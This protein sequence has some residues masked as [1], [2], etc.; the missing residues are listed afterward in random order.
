VEALFADD[1]E[2]AVRSWVIGLAG[3]NWRNLVKAVLAV[4]GDVLLLR[5]DYEKQGTGWRGGL[6]VLFPSLVFAV[7]VV[8]TCK[9]CARGSNVHKRYAPNQRKPAPM[10]GNAPAANSFTHFQ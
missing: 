7:M 9:S 5:R 2:D 1:A 8:R 6:P 4:Y 3:R 10:A